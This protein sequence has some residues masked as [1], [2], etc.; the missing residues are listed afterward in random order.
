ILF[1]DELG[2]FPRHVLDSLRQPL[3]D[4]EIVISRK[5]ASVRFPARVQ[6]LAATNPCPCGFHGDRVVACRC[7]T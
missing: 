7:S 1:L 2:E 4:G 6:L 3:E 5:G